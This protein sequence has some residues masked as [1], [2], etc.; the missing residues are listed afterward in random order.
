MKPDI[1]DYQKNN[2]T[3]WALGYDKRH[4][5]QTPNWQFYVDYRSLSFSSIEQ[6]PFFKLFKNTSKEL[7]ICDASAGLGRDSYLITELGFHVD[8][9]ELHPVLFTLMH[10]GYERCLR[11][12]SK[13]YLHLG[14]CEHLIGKTIMPDIIYFDPMFEKKITLSQKYTQVLQHYSVV[15]PETTAKTFEFLYNY[16][17]TRGL[18]LILKQPQKSKTTFPKAHH[19]LKTSKT[20]EC[21]VYQF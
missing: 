7:K 8:S 21:W 12:Q 3:S 2:D 16:C 5:I 15:N 20:C 17:R 11:R 18:R 1:S 19:Q 9:I 13:W 4:L 14:Q 6:N 10:E